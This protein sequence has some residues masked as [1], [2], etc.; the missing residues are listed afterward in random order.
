[1]VL[2]FRL[3]AASAAAISAVFA[4]IGASRSAGML[5]NAVHA[6]QAEALYGTG[7]T[8]VENVRQRADPLQAAPPCDDAG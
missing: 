5:R 3:A 6:K 1:M 8:V 7:R 2:R 4:R